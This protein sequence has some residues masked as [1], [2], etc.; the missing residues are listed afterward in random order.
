M[1][2][3]KKDRGYKEGDI[4]ELMEFADG[5]NTGRSIRALVTYMLEEHT[6]LAEGYCI[7]G[8]KVIP[9]S[10]RNGHRG[11]Q[12]M[13]Y[14]QWKKNYKKQHGHNPP[15]SEDKR[16]RNKK[17]ANEFMA[18]LYSTGFTAEK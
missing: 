17:I 6:G 1:E 10:D 9:G 4:L 12:K 2:L 11:R 5:R 16:K 15:I 3:R 13:N 7:M 8:I 14:R 18:A